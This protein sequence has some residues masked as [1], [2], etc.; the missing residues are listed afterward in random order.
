M[1]IL[2]ADPHGQYDKIVNFCSR[3]ELTKEDTLILLGDVGANYFGDLRDDERKK[4][5]ANLPCNVLCVHGNHEMRPEHIIKYKLIDYNGGKV[6][7]DCRYP[8]VMFAKDG[9]IFDFDGNKCLVIGGAYSVDKFYRLKKGYLWFDDEQPS[10]EIKRFTEENLSAHKWKV[11]YVFSHTC[12]I[13][14]EPREV[15]LNN[16]E[17]KTVDKTTEIWLGGIEYRLNYKRWY[18][19]HFH[20]DKVQDKVRFLFNDFI[21]L[22]K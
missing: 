17:Q 12:P 9:E 2:N 15:F 13:S 7:Y 18:V 8:G 10:D 1:Y 3:I 11:D 21:E 22:G 5:L 14:Y 16:L 4:Q 19:G 6:W 20:T